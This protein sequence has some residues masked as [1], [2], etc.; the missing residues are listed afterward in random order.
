MTSKLQTKLSRSPFRIVIL[1]GG[2][3]GIASAHSLLSSPRRSDI[4]VTLLES[5]SRFGGW[6][7]TK[8]YSDGC[9]FELGPRTLR[10]VGIAGKRTLRLVEI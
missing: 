10:P 1:G 5:T 9:V 7:N 4:S 3:S 8:T 6:I 2:V